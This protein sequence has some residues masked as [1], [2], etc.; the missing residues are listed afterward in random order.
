LAFLNMN[1]KVIPANDVVGATI[2][3]GEAL[4]G[5]GTVFICGP[6]IAGVKPEIQELPEE[7][8]N[9][10]LIIESS[11]ST[12]TPKRIHLSKEA[13]IASAKATEE[14]FGTSGQWLL[15]LPI[16]Y[17]AGAQ[18]LIRSLV[19][20]TQ[21]VVMN[22]LVSF[23]PEAF[24]RSAQ[25]MTGE[26]RFTSL[27]PTQLK[28]LADVVALDDFV[29]RALQSFTAILVGGQAVDPAVVSSLRDKGV[30]I[31]LS[32]GMA[33]T[34]GG[35][36]YDG[37]ALS[38]VSVEIRD[39]LI[40]IKSPSLANDVADESGF[41]ITQDSGDLVAGKLK[42]LGRADRVLISGALKVSLDSVEAVASSIGGVVE[43]AA[44][45]LDSA[46]WGQRVGLVYVGSPEVAD[47]LAAAVFEQLGLAA[48]PIRVIRVDKLPRLVSGKTDLVSVRKL[49]DV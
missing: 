37:K 15:A 42:V 20:E 26:H 2:A 18:V 11:G 47:Y 3:L 24:A 12:G 35:V 5:N 16:N 48:K 28:R 1:V 32:Y 46:E 40:A 10:A 38:S 7:V 49:F 8:S 4:A 36:V 45:A 23:T 29:L 25:L 27:V 33:E 39:G 21:P 9:T 17:I 19:A 34:A 30:N 31:V 41:L 44:T 22:T 14:Y 6:E 13:L 43:V